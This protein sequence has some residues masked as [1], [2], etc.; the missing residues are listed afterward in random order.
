MLASYDD[1]DRYSGVKVFRVF[2]KTKDAYWPR[3]AG[4]W[5]VAGAD[6]L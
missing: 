4:W 6:L 3:S 1:R 5:L 2:Y